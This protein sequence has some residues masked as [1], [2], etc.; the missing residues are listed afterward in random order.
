MRISRVR[1]RLLKSIFMKTKGKLQIGRIRERD[2]DLTANSSAVEQI[3]KAARLHARLAKAD[4]KAARKS[5]KLA[6]KVAKKTR[7][8]AKAVARKLKLRKRS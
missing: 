6:K 1:R 5:F 2:R 8:N 4:M 3:A 7:K